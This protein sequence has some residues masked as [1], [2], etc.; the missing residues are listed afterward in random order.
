MNISQAKYF[1]SDPELF[2]CARLTC[3]GSEPAASSCWESTDNVTRCDSDE[4]LCTKGARG[5]LCGSCTDRY[6]FSPESGECK[7]CG[8]SVSAIVIIIVA[9]LLSVVL[10]GRNCTAYFKRRVPRCLRLSWFLGILSHVDGGSW[11]VILSTWQIVLS[12]AFNL[13][14]SFP[15]P[16]SSA[17]NGLSWLSINLGGIQCLGWTVYDQVF[18]ASAVPLALAVLISITGQ[19]RIMRANNVNS[20]GCIK[21]HTTWMVLF[22]S[23]F[24]LPPIS[25][26][27]LGAFNCV[28]LSPARGEFFRAL[29]VDT[30]FDCDSVE[31]RSFEVL[32]GCIAAMYLGFPLVWL[33]LLWRVK[34]RLMPLGADASDAMVA[35]ARSSDET[36]A[37]ISFLFASYRPELFYWETV[38]M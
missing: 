25:S 14:V 13:E 31:H 29:R 17:L 33:I 19:V 27:Q 18:F 34:R 16:F 36:L 8:E 9:A 2:P 11:K 20:Q 30:A 32:N 22:L 12:V 35:R 7:E 3:K 28:K 6:F 1:S 15:D 37:P 23:F 24:V 4:L 38:E 26:L 21:N 5:P 10:I